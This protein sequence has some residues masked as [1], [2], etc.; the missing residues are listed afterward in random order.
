M[1]DE[2]DAYHRRMDAIVRRMWIRVWLF[3]IIFS[4]AV[5]SLVWFDR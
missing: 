1:N 5:G 2:I 3:L 4:A